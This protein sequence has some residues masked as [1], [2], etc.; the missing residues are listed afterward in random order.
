MA[1]LLGQHGKE[2]S[3][4]EAFKKFEILAYQGWI[5]AQHMLGNMYA[6][7]DGV[8]QNDV[9]TYAWY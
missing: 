4:K 7:G 1:H 6:K 8:T 3:S 2:K 9:K 5:T